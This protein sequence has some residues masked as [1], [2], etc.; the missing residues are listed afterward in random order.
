MNTDPRGPW[1]RSVD[2]FL[3]WGVLVAVVAAALIGLA[4]L[5]TI[6]HP[7]AGPV[8]GGPTVLMSQPLDGARP[9]VELRRPAP[10]CDRR[11][12]CPAPASRDGTSGH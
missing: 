6:R 9:S 10:P 3:S 2:R 7:A 4:L 1:S 11:E 5:V 12:P 8:P